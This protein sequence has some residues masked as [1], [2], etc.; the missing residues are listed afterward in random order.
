MRKKELAREVYRL[1][2]CRVLL[3]DPVKGS[4]LLKNGSKSSLVAKDKENQVRNTILL[5]LKAA[6]QSQKVNVFSQG[7]DGILRYQSRLYVLYED[8]LR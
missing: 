2:K 6:V 8:D 7:E 3:V 4:I 1:E 5:R